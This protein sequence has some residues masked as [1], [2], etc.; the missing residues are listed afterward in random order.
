M[1]AVIIR[2]IR[3]L[4]MSSISGTWAMPAAE[5]APGVLVEVLIEAD[6]HRTRSRL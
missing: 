6:R 2:G 1:L 3:Y 4:R 5:I